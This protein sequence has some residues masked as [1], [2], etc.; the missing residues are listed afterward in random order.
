MPNRTVLLAVRL[1]PE[2]D[3]LARV[4]AARLGGMSRQDYL[5]LLLARDNNEGSKP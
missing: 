5:R 3:E 1:T 2:E 4:A